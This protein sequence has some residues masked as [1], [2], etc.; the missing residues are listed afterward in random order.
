VQNSAY[1]RDVTAVAART[2][3]GIILRSSLY[4]DQP[5]G[6]WGSPYRGKLARPHLASPLGA[7]KYSGAFFICFESPRY[8]LALDFVFPLPISVTVGDVL[9]R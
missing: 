7:R 3:E 5:Q 8:L 6:L 9:P 4:G 2:V 1:I